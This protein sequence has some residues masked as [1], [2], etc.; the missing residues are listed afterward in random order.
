[1]S[2]VHT[3]GTDVV[4]GVWADGRVGTFR[5]T[6]TG[7]SGYGGLVYTTEGNKALGPYNGYDPLL[8][9]IIKY[10]EDGSMPVTPEETLEIFTFMEAADESKRQG[11]KPVKLADVLAKARKG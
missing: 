7:K 9:D 10:F 3:E 4:V 8:V 11:G 6:R 5:G 2:R 1:V